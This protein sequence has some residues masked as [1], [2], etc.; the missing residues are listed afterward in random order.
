MA[1]AP[2]ITLY[3]RQSPEEERASRA[4]LL[5]AATDWSGLSPRQLGPLE[6]NPWVF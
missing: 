2:D 1:A 6:T 4:L 3:C 5:Q